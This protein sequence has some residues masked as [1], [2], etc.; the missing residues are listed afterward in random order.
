MSATDNHPIPPSLCPTCGYAMD[1]ASASDG[2]HKP[3]ESEISLCFG[4]GAALQFDANL[5]P[6]LVTLSDLQAL[7]REDPDM[8][9]K[10]EAAHREIMRL[11]AEFPTRETTEGR[12]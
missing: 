9:R 4:C 10:L 6:R 12:A 11:R 5:R 8:L 1:R 2:D 3:S 7:A